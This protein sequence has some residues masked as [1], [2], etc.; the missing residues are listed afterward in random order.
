[1][2]WD[3]A[4]QRILVAYAEYAAAPSTYDDIWVAIFSL[5]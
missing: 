1:M 2:T 3:A 4:S 5:E